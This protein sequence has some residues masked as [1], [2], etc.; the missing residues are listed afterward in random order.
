MSIADYE[1]L[2]AAERREPCTNCKVSDQ[3]C[4]RRVL[5]GGKACCAEC[6]Y[7]DTH[8]KAPTNIEPTR[9]QREYAAQVLR[10]VADM[11]TEE[12]ALPITATSSPQCLTLLTA[13]HIVN[14]RAD[15]EA[16]A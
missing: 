7:T 15:L 2:R 6:Y 12:A 4:T 14:T 3:T 13:A 8:P 16:K 11:L 9:E 5:S 1:T 10:E